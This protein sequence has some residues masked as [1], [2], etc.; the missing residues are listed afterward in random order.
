MR[1]RPF[2]TMVVALVAAALAGCSAAKPDG[3]YYRSGFLTD[4]DVLEPG[5][6]G[7]ARLRYEADDAQWSAYPK[8]IL[9]RVTIWRG[10]DRDVDEIAREDLVRLATYM[11]QAF[12]ERLRRDHEVV[13]DPGPGVLR[14]RLA[15]TDVSAETDEL[16]VYST[17]LPPPEHVGDADLVGSEASEFLALANVEVEV[18]DSRTDEVLF[19]GVTRDIGGTALDG[20]ADSYAE[21]ERVFARWASRVSDALTTRQQE[22]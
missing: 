20:A 7:E 12:L 13:H 5:A 16:V 14:L 2:T 3:E 18:T 21:V 17:V 6:E 22:R 9:D 11:Y 4:Y 15:L 1:K 19:A 10:A 8:I